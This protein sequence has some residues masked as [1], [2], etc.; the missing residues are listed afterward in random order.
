LNSFLASQRP[1]L[2]I[3][4]TLM[5]GELLAASPPPVFR[6]CIQFRAQPFVFC[7]TLDLR[8][9]LVGFLA[10]LLAD[11]DTTDGGTCSDVTHNT[12]WESKGDNF[13]R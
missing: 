12:G 13:V 8:H 2:D 4:R 6:I 1:S 3:V 5:F 9:C 7:D 10:R 11:F